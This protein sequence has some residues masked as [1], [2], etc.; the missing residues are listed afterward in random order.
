MQ[1]PVR[2]NAPQWIPS[3]NRYIRLAQRLGLQ[4]RLAAARLGGRQPEIRVNI[5]DQWIRLNISASRELRRAG[6]HHLESAMI[7]HLLAS[8]KPG[9]VVYDVGANIGIISLMLALR[10]GD[11]RVHAFEPEPR[12][13]RQ[14]NRNIQANDLTGRVS[15]HQLALSDGEG[16]VELFVRGTAGEGRHSIAARKGSTDSIRVPMT[17]MSEFARKTGESPDVVKID[18][19]GAEGS[20]VAGMEALIRT[21]PPRHIF[22]EIHNKGLRDR[23]PDGTPLRSWLESRGYTLT[24]EQQRRSGIHCHFE[25]PPR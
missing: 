3:T 6:E 23:M 25:A 13:F 11:C 18:V 22:M 20:V 12:N 10:S 9:A 4:A 16:E 8:V 2:V 21:S 19:E 24:W 1:H 5:M 7:E 17:T 15:G 14:L